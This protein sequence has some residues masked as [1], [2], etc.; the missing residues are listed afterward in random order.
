MIVTYGINNLKETEIMS[1]EKKATK[2][3][4]CITVLGNIKNT[5]IL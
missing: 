3:G 4:G 1:I 2:I 5:N